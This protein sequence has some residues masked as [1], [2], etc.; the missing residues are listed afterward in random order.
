[1]FAI[2]GATV[3]ATDST[4][5]TEGNNAYGAHSRDNHSAV[6]LLRTSV[7][8]T[9]SAAHG[10]VA[11]KGGL[12]TGT[13]T[14]ISAQ[15][16]NAAALYA[17]GSATHISTAQFTDSTLTNVSGPTVGVAGVA[18]LAFTSSTISGSGEWLK[19]GTVNDFPTLANSLPVFALS[20]T[21]TIN[22]DSSLIIGSATTRPGSTSN[23]TFAN[24][25]LWQMTGDSNLTNLINNLSTVEFTP[26]GGAYKTLT[27]DN[28]LDGSDSVFIMNTHIAANSG[29]GDQDIHTINSDF[30]TVS[31][32]ATGNH[33]INILD[34][35]AGAI[36]GNEYALWLVHTGSSEASSTFSGTSNITQGTTTYTYSVMNGTDAQA[37]VNSSSNPYTIAN[38]GDNDW[39]ILRTSSTGANNGDTIRDIS[40]AS[41]TAWFL[42]QD[43][44]LKRMGELRLNTR[45]SAN[46]DG[47][48]GK[49]SN[50]S[51]KFVNSGTHEDPLIDD[52]WVRGYGAQ[53]N[54]S[55]KVGGS[56]FKQYTYG[57]DAGLDHSWLDDEAENIYYLGAYAGYGRA[58]QSYRS[59]AGEGNSDSYY[60][61]FYG[62]WLNNE[63]WYADLVGKAA[64]Y[65]N[66]FKAWDEDTLTTG[67]Y[68]N[69]ALGISLE[70]GRQFQF[71]DNWYAEPQIQASY[72]HFFGGNYRTGG[73]NQFPV[74]YDA[75]DVLQFRYGSLFGRTIKLH[76]D[77][78]DDWSFIQPYVKIF[79]Q[80]QI[81]GGGHISS[82][83]DR[84]RPNTDGWAAVVGAGIIW[85]IDEQNQL[86]LDYEATLAEKYDKPWG[87]NFGFR[88]QF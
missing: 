68:G 33:R 55:D 76:K 3:N 31:G 26:S 19:V 5:V 13:Q 75:A 25:N 20:G 65:D 82:G 49:D 57:V 41:R 6:E 4:V 47:Y 78:P 60:G 39:Y 16:D 38:N 86:H 84:W 18:E 61:G 72:V 36:T 73:D 12:V 46:D 2:L 74:T 35:S 88:H 8:T 37:K 24:D 22:A 56:A 79:G 54:V 50:T 45:R 14:T 80:H 34:T 51:A 11:D 48:V 58:D 81:S 32:T 67:D 66:N 7:T 70:L 43:T 42:E 30:L 69:W 85:Q 52:I 15:G 21:A 17:A 77:R 64:Y 9:G 23:V 71:K 44:L 59:Y 28:N 29:A 62:T 10:V 27:L 83:D 87:L 63:G 1:M 53:Y 40:T